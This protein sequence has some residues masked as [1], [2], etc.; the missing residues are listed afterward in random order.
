MTQAG[1]RDHGQRVGHDAGMVQAPDHLRLSAHL[2]EQVRTH[3]AAELPNEGVGLLAARLTMEG[4]KLVATG[5]RFYPGRNQRASPTRYD[6]D[7]RDLVAAL[8]EIEAAGDVLGGIVHSH[9][10]GE[11]TPSRTDLAEAYYPE[12]LM[13][14]VSFATSS[15]VLRAWKLEGESGAWK[16]RQVPVDLA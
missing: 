1:K 16:P 2:W 9:P 3:L 12:S 11:P 4:E 7:V 6:L 14:I 15:P 13:L 10:V 5:T 8:G